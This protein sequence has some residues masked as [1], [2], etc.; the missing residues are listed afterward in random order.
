MKNIMKKIYFKKDINHIQKKINMLGSTKMDAI[1]FINMRVITTV[2]LGIFLIFLTDIS[3]LLIPFLI[4]LYYYFYYQV[5]IQNKLK[6][7][8]EKLNREALYFFE[9]LTLTLESGKNLQNS[10][11]LTCKNIDSELS[12]EFLK[13]L[14]EVKVGKT[15]I[16]ALGDMQKRIPSENINN[17]IMNIMQTNYFGNSIIDTM[18]S[19]VDYLREKQILDIKG[20]IN[21]IPNK[22]SVVS[23][24]FIVP[25]I[26]LL[27]LGPYIVSFL[28]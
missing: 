2:L 23:V 24:L 27:I 8:E 15:L 4:I 11:E 26:L 21:K 5:I 14:N 10:L 6:K 22:I 16:E 20:Q 3:Y 25:L 13:S 12:N 28:G 7:R 1:S 17:I 9:V 18:N 19:Q